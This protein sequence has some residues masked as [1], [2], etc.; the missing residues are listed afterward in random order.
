M[1]LFATAL[2]I[3]GPT[4]LPARPLDYRRIELWIPTPGTEDYEWRCIQDR[5]QLSLAYVLLSCDL[6]EVQTFDRYGRNTKS[7]ISVH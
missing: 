6:T 3:L 2:F 4:N 1:I 5:N 7:F